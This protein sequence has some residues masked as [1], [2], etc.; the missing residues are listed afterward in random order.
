M[1]MD[2]MTA[3]AM[4]GTL[5]G[6]PQR[7]TTGAMEPTTPPAPHTTAPMQATG[8]TMGVASPGTATRGGTTG[9][10]GIESTRVTQETRTQPRGG[11]VEEEE[12]R[13]GL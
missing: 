2:P 12:V 11:R 4:K 7:F 6:Q 8:Y 3:G 9:S 5:A 10:T 1:G 13:L